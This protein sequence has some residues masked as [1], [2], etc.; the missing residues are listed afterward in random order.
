M[1]GSLHL[2]F[3]LTLPLAWASSTP[4]LRTDQQDR[5]LGLFSRRC[6]LQLENCRKRVGE[7]PFED[8]LNQSHE[9]SDPQIQTQVHNVILEARDKVDMRA[10]VQGLH[11]SNVNGAALRK[12]QREYRVARATALDGSLEESKETLRELIV[13]ARDV[14]AVPFQNI[15]APILEFLLN[16]LDIDLAGIVEEACDD[17][18]N[19]VSTLACYFVMV[20]VV[21]AILG[22]II[23]MMVMVLCIPLLPLCIIWFL[24]NQNEERVPSCQ[25]DLLQCQYEGILH[26]AIPALLKITTGQK[27][28]QSDLPSP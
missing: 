14:M 18:P 15:L 23:A 6:E 17:Q 7:S 28:M 5:E 16:I 2:V 8:W 13:S 3:L 27:L 12:L 26:V 9:I 10:L 21:Y 25:A 19:V 4:N 24:L 1:H 11:P 20:I 22:V